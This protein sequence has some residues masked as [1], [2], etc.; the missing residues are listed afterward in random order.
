MKNYGFEIHITVDC[1]T[2]EQLVNFKN[3]CAEVDAKP[4]VIN[5]VQSKQ[6]MTSKVVYTSVDKI[7]ETAFSD[8]LKMRKFGFEAKRIKIEAEPRF[9]DDTQFPYK[10]LEIHVPCHTDKL[11]LL[12]EKS[13]YNWHRSKNEF[14]DGVTFLTYRVACCDTVPMEIKAIDHYIG[15][16]IDKGAVHESFK[17]HYEYAIYDTHAQLDD[18]WMNKKIA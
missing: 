15:Y 12:S 9:I 1:T 7:F 10:Y 13:L 14:K 2:E 5:L 3:F 17:H 8:A 18:A 4:I 16:F 11:N 6:V